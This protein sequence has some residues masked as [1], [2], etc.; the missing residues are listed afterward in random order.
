MKKIISM[1]SASVLLCGSF[2]FT[3]NAREEAPEQMRD[4]TTME[5]VRD[6]GIGINLGNTFDA[7][8]DWIAE[9]GDGSVQSY[10]TAWGSPV[11]TKD[12][13]QGYADE[14]FGVLRIPTAWSNMMVQDGTYTINPQWMERI[15]EI[16]D[17]TLDTGMYAIV[18]IHWDNGWVNTF[19]DDKD[20][21][22]KRFEIMWTQISGNFKNYGDRLMFE[23]QNEEFGWDSVWN[24]WAGNDGKPESYQ[25]VNEINQ[26]FVDTVRKNGG[27]NDKRHLLISGYNTGIDVTC[28]PLFKMPYDPV[29]RCAISV[30]Y[31][32]PPG[33]AILEE[34]ADW[35]KAISTWGTE[36]DYNELNTNLDMMK[37]NFIDKGI[38]VII[39][40]YGCPIKN[41]EPESVRRFLSSVCEAAY[42]R[43]MC[44]V[45]WD[46]P[47]G[48]YDREE[49]HQL[50]DRELRELFRKI[51]DKP[52]KPLKITGDVNSDGELSTADLVMLQ[53]WLL[54]SEPL[55]DSSAADMNKDGKVNIYD[56]VFMRKELLNKKIL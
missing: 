8:G 38:P 9:W 7:C 49:T 46:T 41:K 50:N 24:K 55:T 17:W 11:I 52:V 25:L 26:K 28:D 40:E 21:C 13:I 47:G 19:P 10:E 16:V 30:H 14:G 22:M 34:D 56:M 42:K 37:T 31:Y 6:M 43:Q 32:T 27:N 45:L 2:T 29:G 4:I 1:F 51:C 39:G 20:E 15:T 12:I 36:A 53:K 48:H 5:L 35:G 54:S 23:A 44:P 33:F 18:N 3:T